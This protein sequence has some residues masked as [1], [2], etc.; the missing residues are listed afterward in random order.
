MSRPPRHDTTVLAT[1]ER[2]RRLLL[3]QA[4][5]RQ[6]R[7]ETL[8]ARA[9]EAL[10]KAER[11]LDSAHAT[12]RA[13]VSEG[14]ALAVQDLQLAHQYATARAAA[15]TQLHAAREQRLRELAE[16]REQLAARLEDLKAIEKLRERLQRSE[17]KWSRRQD[18]SRL[19]E[20]GLIRG[21]LEVTC[22]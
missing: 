8:L 5:A 19:D 22:R 7:H 14:A 2:H 4:R 18:Q 3:D 1:L 17:S 12:Q 15:L 21:S 10:G 16:A 11:L 13:A 20:L 6:A 9:E